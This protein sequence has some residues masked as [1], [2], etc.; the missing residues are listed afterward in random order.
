MTETDQ[1]F[2]ERDKTIKKEKLL[3]WRGFYLQDEITWSNLLVAQKQKEQ[4]VKD[5][6]K[7]PICNVYK[8]IRVNRLIERL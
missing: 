4:G 5:A 8:A 7:V 6:I 3:A 1:Y 2:K